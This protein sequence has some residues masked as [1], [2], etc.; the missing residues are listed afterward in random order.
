VI[1]AE[2]GRFLT[3]RRDPDRERDD[4]GSMMTDHR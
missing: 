1:S 4:F 2:I 3:V